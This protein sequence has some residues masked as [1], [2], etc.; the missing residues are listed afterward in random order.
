MI[1]SGAQQKQRDS[2]IHIHVS[3]LPK[4]PSHPDHITLE[5]SSLCHIVDPCWLSV[6]NMQ[7]TCGSNPTRSALT[8]STMGVFLWAS[9]SCCNHAGICQRPAKLETSLFLLLF[10]TI[11]LHQA[12]FRQHFKTHRDSSSHFPL[13]CHFYTAGLSSTSLGWS[14]PLEGPIPA[15]TISSTTPIHAAPHCCVQ[16]RLTGTCCEPGTVQGAVPREGKT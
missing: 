3:I 13:L 7:H 16:E 4:L 1:V 8:S 15:A 9:S 14:L 10:P 11:P 6:L 5:Q 2:A 12:K